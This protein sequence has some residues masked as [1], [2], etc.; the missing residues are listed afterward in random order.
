MLFC[1]CCSATRADFSLMVDG[2]RAWIAYGSWHNYAIKDGV[3]DWRARV[4]PDWLR[5][6]HQIAVQ[7][8]DSSFTR[9]LTAAEGGRA[10][11]VTRE[12]QESPSFFKR[13]GFF[14]IIHGDL[15]CFCRVGS[16]AKV[17]VATDPMG[18]WTYVTQL[19]PISG[20]EGGD[21]GGGGGGGDG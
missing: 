3:G 9:P 13:G 7:P 11:T 5:E 14:Y 18:P 15:C 4:Y 1:D 21:G 17:L 6:G 19:N 20:R 12:S 2:D 16:D 8:L 10:V